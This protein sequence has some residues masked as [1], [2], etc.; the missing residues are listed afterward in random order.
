MKHVLVPVAMLKKNWSMLL[1]VRISNY[2]YTQ[3]ARFALGCAWSIEFLV[4]TDVRHSEGLLLMA[5][6]IIMKQ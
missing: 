6:S 5:L 2:G 1:A 3:E 4:Q